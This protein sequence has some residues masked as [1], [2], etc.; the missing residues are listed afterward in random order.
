M[1]FIIVPETRLELVQ[2]FSPRDFKQMLLWTIS[3]PYRFRRRVG[4]SCMLLRRLTS[5]VVSTPSLVYQCLARSQVF[6][7]N[8]IHPIFNMNV[9]IQGGTHSTA[10]PHVYHS[11]TP[12][13][14]SMN[15]YC[16]LHK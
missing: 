1:L 13:S 3:S 7:L 4:R 5:H 8:R 16:S 9:S 11:I 12:A 14:F 15:L 10:F 6:S 2:A